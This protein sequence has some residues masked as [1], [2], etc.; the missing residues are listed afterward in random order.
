MRNHRIHLLAPLLTAL[1]A[2]CGCLPQHPRPVPHDLQGTWTLTSIEYPEGGTV[3]YPY[4]GINFC[5]IY[6]AD[7]TLHECRLQAT[8]AGIVV[9]PVGSETY[10]LIDRGN[11]EVLYLEGT[12]PRPLTE[13]NDTTIVI[14][15][16]GRKYT[17]T[18][19]QGI[20]QSHAD[21][22]R[23][24]ITASADAPDSV[25]C[26]YVLSTTERR[27]QQTNH[28][29]LYLITIL[30]LTLTLIA[31]Y[32]HTVRLRNKRT[33]QQLAQISEEQS[34]RP[35]PIRNAMKEVEDA[36]LSSDY[37]IALR[38][39]IADGE[40]I[41]PADW[42]ELEQHV[43]HTYPG[44]TNRLFN[45]CAMSPTEYQVCL[46]VKLRIPPTEIA[47][48][49]IKD[50]STISSIRSRLYQKVFQRKGS[51]REWDSFILTL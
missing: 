12:W 30:V 14:Q 38:K 11:H 20:S 5:R 31:H 6:C 28:T 23:R 36:F 15:Q 25:A 32:A 3:S 4:K 13:V 27:L 7:S 51:S 2:L 10:T 45:L 49:L 39:R 29:L 1:F 43:R 33:E 8:L 42:E 40:R 41:R 50:T 17:W 47:A 48:V 46:L 18:R 19:A 16:N 26:H 44:F 35:Q 34:L 21:E 24:I 9:I 37:Y 22:I